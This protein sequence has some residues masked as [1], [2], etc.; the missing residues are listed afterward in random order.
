MFSIKALRMTVVTGAFTLLAAMLPFVTQA[1]TILRPD[2]QISGALGAI[3]SFIQGVLIPFLF[4]VGFFMFVWGIIKFFVIGGSNDDA[5][6]EGK[7]LIIY[8]LAGFVVIL[9]FWG[10]VNILAQGIGLQN[11]TLINTPG[12]PAPK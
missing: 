12:L 11:E 3:V 1:Q 8:A 4:A 9:I 2:N 5:K 6:K 7:S 10:L